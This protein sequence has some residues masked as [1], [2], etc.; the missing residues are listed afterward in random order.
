MNFPV[1][2]VSPAPGSF[3]VTSNVVAPIQNFTPILHPIFITPSSLK[4]KKG[5]N[6]HEL[7]N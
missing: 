1:L 2:L 5:K 3:T 4:K 7:K 6:I